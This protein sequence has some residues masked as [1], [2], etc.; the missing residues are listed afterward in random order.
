[1]SNTI[2]KR[3]DNIILK[4]SK[5]KNYSDTTGCPPNGIIT[6]VEQLTLKLAIN[7]TLLKS[8]AK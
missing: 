2:Q 8:K 3:E 5:D 7:C 4:Y 1:M 6:L